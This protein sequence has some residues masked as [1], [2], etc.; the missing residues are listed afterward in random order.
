MPSSYFIMLA[1][2][3]SAWAWVESSFMYMIK[4]EEY[5]KSYLFTQRDGV[6]SDEVMQEGVALTN[7]PPIDKSKYHQMKDIIPRFL[8]IANG[9]RGNHLSGEEM[10]SKYLAYKGVQGGAVLGTVLT[11]VFWIIILV[12]VFASR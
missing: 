2:L 12:V 7:D 10:V 8:E 6:L 11:S 5:H 9:Q 4:G 3:T 1:I